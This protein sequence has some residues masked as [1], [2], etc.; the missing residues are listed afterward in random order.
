[1]K[2]L[3]H[4]A[5]NKLQTRIILNPH[6]PNKNERFGAISMS[7]TSIHPSV[8]IFVSSSYLKNRF[9]YFDDTSHFYRTG[10]D[11]VSRTTMGALALILF[12]LSPLW[13]F[14]VHIHVRS[15]TGT[16]FEI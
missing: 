2:R 5:H 8:N 14:S 4:Y 15:V 11:D 13:C 16:T 3:M 6:I 1:M 7:L 10:H 12:A 9:E